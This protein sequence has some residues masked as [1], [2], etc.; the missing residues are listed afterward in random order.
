[1][2]IVDWNKICIQDARYIHKH[3]VG[4]F[5]EDLPPLLHRQAALCKSSRAQ[6]FIR[7]VR[8]NNRTHTLFPI[9]PTLHRLCLLSQL[10]LVSLWN[11]T[12]YFPFHLTYPWIGF[13]EQFSCRCVVH[14]TA[15]FGPSQQSNYNEIIINYT[16]SL[17]FCILYVLSTVHP[18]MI[19]VN[20]QIDAQFFMYVYFYSLHVSGS[21]VPIIRRII[22]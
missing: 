14:K 5:S 18:G 20:N 22:V 4:L 11:V 6:N 15:Y 7:A 8:T 3:T 1:L 13:Q 9:K 17:S 21:H 12:V 10:S 2:C 19:L 16:L